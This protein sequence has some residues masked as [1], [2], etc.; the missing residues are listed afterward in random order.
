LE[1]KRKQIVWSSGI[2]LASEGRK[3]APF[4]RRKVEERGKTGLIDPLKSGDPTLREN[5]KEGYAISEAVNEQRK[6]FGS[7]SFAGG[8]GATYFCVQRGKKGLSAEDVSQRGGE[9]KGFLSIPKGGGRRPYSYNR[10]RKENI[11]QDHGTS[12]LEDGG[13]VLNDRLSEVFKKGLRISDKKSR[14]RRIVGSTR[15]QASDEKRGKSLTR[16]DGEDFSG[17]EKECS[18]S[19]MHDHSSGRIHRPRFFQRGRLENELTLDRR[20][21]SREASQGRRERETIVD[22]GVDVHGGRR[23]PSLQLRSHRGQKKGS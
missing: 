12:A 10:E 22:K 5:K 7:G 17:K 11:A 15:N 21:P 3:E 18:Q 1:R 23:G 20:R 13:A 8:R 16:K 9:G 2:A 14:E 4:L 19:K 6:G